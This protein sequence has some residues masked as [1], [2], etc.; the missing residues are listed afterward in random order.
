[1]GRED[2]TDAMLVYSVFSGDTREGKGDSDSRPGAASLLPVAGGLY[3]KEKSK[4]L[5]LQ[6]RGGPVAVTTRDA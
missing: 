4:S 6:A 1:M 5:S 3:A 2:G